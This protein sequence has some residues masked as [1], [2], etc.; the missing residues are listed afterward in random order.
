MLGC[1]S[2]AGDDQGVAASGDSLSLVRPL[3]PEPEYPSCGGIASIPCYRRAEICV[4]DPRDTC[5]PERGGA[6]CP[7]IC[8][9]Y[10]MCGGFGGFPCDKNEECIDDPTDDCEPHNGGAD[11]PGVCRPLFSSAL[12]VSR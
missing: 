7:G 3:P 6:D 12:A 4:D 1:T 9:P 10:K 11:C 2:G 8:V 5:N